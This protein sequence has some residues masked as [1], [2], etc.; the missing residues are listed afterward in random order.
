MS[1]LALLRQ[2][3][4]LTSTYCVFCFSFVLRVDCWPTQAYIRGCELVVIDRSGGGRK[5]REQISLSFEMHHGGDCRP[6]YSPTHCRRNPGGG[7]C[8][9]EA[10]LYLHHTDRR[11]KSAY[12]S[13]H[14]C[15]LCALASRTAVRNGHRRPID[16]DTRERD[17][18]RQRDQIKCQDQVQEPATAVEG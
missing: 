8:A 11:G 18:W 16:S 10:P 2:D 12:V 7:A 15:R 1:N 13:I 6:F 9:F 5:A 4:L 14:P 3:D 17:K